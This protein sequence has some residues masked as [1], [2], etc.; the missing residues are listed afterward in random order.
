[1]GIF[2]SGGGRKKYCDYPEEVRR[3]KREGKL[4]EAETLLLRLIAETEAE[5][6]AK[7]WGVA[8]W[9]YHQLRPL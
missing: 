8:P 4:D 7:G 2:G 6:K 9:Y 1:M 5:S 3:L